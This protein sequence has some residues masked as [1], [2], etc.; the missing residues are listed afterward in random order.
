MNRRALLPKRPSSIQSCAIC[1][2][3][4]ALTVGP[5]YN[6]PMLAEPRAK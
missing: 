3:D 6:L 4:V 5:N 2:W 1:Y